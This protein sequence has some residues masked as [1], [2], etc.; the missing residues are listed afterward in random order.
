MSLENDSLDMVFR[1]SSYEFYVK[2]TFKLDYIHWK[3]VNSNILKKKK[4]N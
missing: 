2:F 1:I 3:I 4:K